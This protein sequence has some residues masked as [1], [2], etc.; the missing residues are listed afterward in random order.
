MPLDWN[1]LFAPRMAGVTASE[2]RELLKLIDQ[3]D[4]ISFA[5]GI[6]DPDLFPRD[7]ILRAHER[8]LQSNSLA[9]TA[10]QYTISEGYTPLRDWI[11]GRCA[12]ARDEILVTNGSQQ[13]L[14]F[15]GKLLISP[16]DKVVVTAPT[17][18]G[19]LQAFS[20]YQPQYIPV[21][22]DADGILPD[23]L[24]V[25]LAQRPRFLYLVPDFAN[26]NGVTLSLERRRQVVALCRRFGVPLIEDAAYSA[27]RYDGEPLP[28]L[29]AI[30]LEAGQEGRV[31][32]HAGT[33]SKTVVPALRVG[34]LAGPAPVIQKLVL[35]KQAAD[36]HVGTLNQMVMHAVVEEIYDSHV[37]VLRGAYHRRRDAMLAALQETMPEGVTWTR[38]AGG[39]F[40]WL[41]LPA[42]IDGARMLE[43][44]VAEERVA[45]V[46][47]A[48][49]FPDRSGKATCRLSFTTNR[50]ERIREGVGRLAALMGRMAEAPAA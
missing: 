29:L 31:V 10:L 49:F 4:V 5:G 1:G 16:G 17:Y 46:P 6:P 2:I 21:P 28:T 27:L 8:V 34:W 35:V 13:G 39:M 43:R 12:M 38:P 48:A 42:G 36:L 7:A 9:A 22:T 18:L 45:F 19:A 11:A 41:N 20:P 26:P 23:E 37:A 33:F 40:V 50:P 14:D 32:I 3:P 47:G 24:E 44:S 25:A 15:L 30:D